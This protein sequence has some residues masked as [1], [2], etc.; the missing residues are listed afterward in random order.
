VLASTSTVTS[1]YLTIPHSPSSIIKPPWSLT[2]HTMTTTTTSSTTMSWIDSMLLGS[3]SNKN[4]WTWMWPLGWLF[5]IGRMYYKTRYGRIECP[6]GLL[7]YN[8][9][10]P[11]SSYAFV[12]QTNNNKKMTTIKSSCCGLWP[13]GHDDN[14]VSSSSVIPVGLESIQVNVSSHSHNLNKNDYHKL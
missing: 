4:K 9:C 11:P 7:K 12:E 10:C 2:L 14:D 1:K 5:G 8:V 3:N 13:Y 6:C